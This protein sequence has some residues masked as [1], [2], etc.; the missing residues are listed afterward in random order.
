M[1]QSHLFYLLVFH[2]P[3]HVSTITTCYVIQ[4]ILFIGRLIYYILTIVYC[5]GSG[6]CGLHQMSI[7][8]A[9]GRATVNC[10]VV[11]VGG[12]HI[13]IDLLQYIALNNIF[14]D[15]QKLAA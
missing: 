1:I 9:F 5:G 6:M 4:L 7:R 3:L 14:K 11:W 10:G 13:H 2:S 8:I 12:A 15:I